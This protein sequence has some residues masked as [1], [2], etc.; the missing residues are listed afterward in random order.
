MG[1]M[2]TNKDLLGLQET[3]KE[4]IELI[5]DTADMFLIL[6]QRERLT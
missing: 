2:L 4:D 1:E 6:P 3:S 5:L